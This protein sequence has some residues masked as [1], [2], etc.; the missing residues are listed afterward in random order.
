VSVATDLRKLR[1]AGKSDAD[2]ASELGC[3]V[4]SVTNWRLG[5]KPRRTF[6]RALA[7]F[8]RRWSAR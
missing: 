3:S 2:I 8:A 4:R 5:K 7:A 1:A 6:A